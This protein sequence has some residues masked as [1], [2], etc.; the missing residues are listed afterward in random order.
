[1]VAAT[2]GISTIVATPH[3][4]DDHPFDIARIAPLTG[5]VNEALRAESIPVRVLAGAEVAISKLPDLTD[6]QL[7]TLCLGSGKYLL[8]ESPYTHATSL[9]EQD[10]FSVQVRGFTPVLAHPERSPSFQTEI[11]RLERLVG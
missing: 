6:D 7:D 5:E 2:A 4:R 8:V 3:V 10:I 1:G 9:L 11:A